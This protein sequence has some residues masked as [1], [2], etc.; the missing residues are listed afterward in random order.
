MNQDKLWRS[1]LWFFRDIYVFSFSKG[2]IYRRGARRWR[3]LYRVNGHIFQAKRFN[4]VSIISFNLN[5][6]LLLFPSFLLAHYDVLFSTHQSRTI[7]SICNLDISSWWI[8]C[9]IPCQRNLLAS[10]RQTSFSIFSRQSWQWFVL[11]MLKNV[12]FCYLND[13]EVSM[14]HVQ[15]LVCKSMNV[16]VDAVW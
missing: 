8:D 4:R 9:Q 14:A 10:E 15:R 5:A 11:W 7:T 2:S 16:E 6:P 1:I 12:G 13:A 3:K